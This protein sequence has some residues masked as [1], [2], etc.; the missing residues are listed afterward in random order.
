MQIAAVWRQTRDFGR[1]ALPVLLTALAATACI[2]EEQALIL[3]DRPEVQADSARAAAD[4]E[5]FDDSG[6]Q[7]D[8]ARR[9]DLDTVDSSDAGDGDTPSLTD[10]TD[11]DATVEVDSDDV[12]ELDGRTG[13]GSALD[14]DVDTQLDANA[15]LDGT[16]EV[17]DT[18]ADDAILD[19]L[20]IPADATATDT[21]D[22]DNATLDAGDVNAADGNGDATATNG[23]QDATPCQGLLDVPEP[24]AGDAEPAAKAS[25]PRAPQAIAAALA[26]VCKGRST[27]LARRP[28]NRWPFPATDRFFGAEP[29]R[30]PTAAARYQLHL[31][32]ERWSAP[33]WSPATAR[34]PSQPSAG[35][36]AQMSAWRLPVARHRAGSP[37]GPNRG[38]WASNSG[39]LW[40]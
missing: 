27:C 33:A 36:Q 35:W 17:A 2:D 37:R 26:E 9:A 34:Q 32:T 28:A 40:S 1:K 24:D 29:R 18:A 39:Q 12:Q 22:L 31:H 3:F 16:S 14:A 38:Y 11:V 23:C 7:F 21:V 20:S 13:E 6:R 15:D 19:G 5:L 30:P 10:G 4:S 8:S 25:T